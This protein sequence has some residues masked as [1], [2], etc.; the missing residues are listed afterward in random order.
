M[1]KEA[2]I[3]VRMSGELSE[4][5]EKLAKATDRSKS[6]LAAQAIEEFVAL[7][8]WQVEA[9]KGGMAAAERGDMAGH[10]EALAILER[11]GRKKNAA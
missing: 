8:E 6:F 3:S 4:R 9:I 11:W 1:K 5:L 10:D 7:Q 2:M